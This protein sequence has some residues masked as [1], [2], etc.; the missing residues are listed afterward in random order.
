M[1]KVAVFLFNLLFANG[2]YK[3]GGALLLMMVLTVLAGIDGL[4]W[5]DDVVLVLAGYAGIVI[6]LY[7]AYAWVINPIRS[8]KEKRAKKRK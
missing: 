7:I 6:L 1:K 5:F 8:L 3:V 2:M 4:E